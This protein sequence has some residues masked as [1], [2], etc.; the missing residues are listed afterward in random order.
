MLKSNKKQL[1]IGSLA[2]VLTLELFGCAKK[3]ISLINTNVNQNQGVN[4]NINQNTSAVATST[5][6]IDTIT[7]A[8][9]IYNMPELRLKLTFPEINCKD[10][11]EYNL[12]LSELHDYC[13]KYYG[14]NLIGKDYLVLEVKESTD[15][16]FV[17]YDYQSLTELFPEDNQELIK[18]SISLYKDFV[19]REKNQYKI[20]IFLN[21][22]INK[23][24]IARWYITKNIMNITT[25]EL[26]Y[27]NVCEAG[28]PIY[29]KKIIGDYIVWQIGIN[30]SSGAGDMCLSVNTPDERYAG[31]EQRK[32]EIA[33]DIDKSIGDLTVFS[34]Y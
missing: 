17:Q 3:P 32:C 25:K 15:D 27:W 33:A 28:C 21:D 5:E 8:D 9:I 12:P 29:S 14:G 30:P 22:K 13:K 11:T 23:K 18:K 19:K 16:F 26:F 20:S 31:D 4:A 1:L 7:P 6:G 2:L 34:L 10:F 24:E